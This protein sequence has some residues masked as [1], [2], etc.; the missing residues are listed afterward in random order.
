MQ[1]Q[2]RRQEE[3][4]KEQ[5]IQRI[6]E[7]RQREYAAEDPVI[8]QIRNAYW[9]GKEA[10]RDEQIRIYEK[11]EKARQAAIRESRGFVD[12]VKY[13]TGYCIGRVWR[14]TWFTLKIIFCII[15]FALLWSGLSALMG[16]H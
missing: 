5:R 16:I 1:E 9:A 4:A 7:Q 2:S 11:A 6:A 15:L 13:Y 10:G 14:A 3:M 8:R 12:S